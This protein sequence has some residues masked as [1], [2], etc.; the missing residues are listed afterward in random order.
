MEWRKVPGFP[1]YSV[2]D[3][4]LVRR[5]TAG[6]GP[7]RPGRVL[8][9]SIRDGRR[10][11]ELPGGETVEVSRLVLLAFVGP[12]PFEGAEADHINE[13]TIDNEL[14]N[15]RWVTHEENVRASFSRGNRTVLKGEEHPASVLSDAD[16]DAMRREYA[17]G[18]ISLRGLGKRYGVDKSTVHAVV[19]NKRR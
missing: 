12:P 2:S 9:G 19:T 4:G 5:D 17:E 11:V 15:L 14:S 18:G 13:D 3:T 10:R 7:A 8:R 1:D 6:R 16:V